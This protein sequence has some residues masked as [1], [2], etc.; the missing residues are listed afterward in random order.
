MTANQYR[1]ALAALGL[2]QAE[3]AEFL[4]IS[5]RAA[6]GYAN[7]MPVPTAIAKLLHLM[8]RLKLKP[9][10]KVNRQPPDKRPRHGVEPPRGPNPAK[11][12]SNGKG[13]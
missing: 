11:G 13:C 4:G 1:A 10:R 9:E 12:G 2:T 8:V 3:A 5:I 7:D 6:H